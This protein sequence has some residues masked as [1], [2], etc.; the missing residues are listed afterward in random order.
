MRLEI[1]RYRGQFSR[2]A[3]VQGGGEPGRQADTR[4][5][6]DRFEFAQPGRAGAI[7]ELCGGL[8]AD[9]FGRESPVSCSR[10]GGR[11]QDG[12]RLTDGA[13]ASG[14]PRPG[15]APLIVQRPKRTSQLVER[16]KR[17]GGLASA[18]AH[19]ERRRAWDVIAVPPA[20]GMARGGQRCCRLFQQQTCGI[21]AAGTKCGPTRHGGTE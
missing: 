10:F 3:V 17:G 15:Q 11:Q 2:I 1:L 12:D 14:H 18:T 4:P 9:H 21:E 6:D 5:L 8:Q 13:L 7:S 16:G 19:G 20:D